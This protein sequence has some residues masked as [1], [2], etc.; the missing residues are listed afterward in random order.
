MCN[1]KR[2][3]LRVADGNWLGYGF[4]LGSLGL[5]LLLVAVV[6]RLDSA[7]AGGSLCLSDPHQARVD[8]SICK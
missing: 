5:G 8:N 4:R 6:V 7:A 3:C 2:G 1:G